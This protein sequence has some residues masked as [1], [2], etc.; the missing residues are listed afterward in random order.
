MKALQNFSKV[1]AN[2]LF[3]HEV[4]PVNDKNSGPNT[5]PCWDQSS[6]F[7]LFMAKPKSQNSMTIVWNSSGGGAAPL[8]LVINYVFITMIL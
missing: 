5:C 4:S 2:E 7:P 1:H 6:H 3:H 8:T